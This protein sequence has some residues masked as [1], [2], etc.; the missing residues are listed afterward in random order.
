M[1]TQENELSLSQLFDVFKKSLIR[2]LIY[3]LVTIITATAVL[4]LVKTFSSTNVY[5]ANISFSKTDETTLSTL[6]SYKANAVNKAIAADG[7]SLDISDEII[8]NLAVSAI[9]PEDKEKDSSFTPTSF[10][11]SLKTDSDLKL[12][13][14]EYKSL[15]DNI[16]KE[17]VNQFAASS[18]P[19]LSE[20]VI[21]VGAQ[22]ENNVE[23]LQIAYYLSDIIDDYLINLESFAASNSAAAVFA[24]SNGKTL[25]GVISDLKF[26]KSYIDSLKSTIVI[27]K[28]GLGNLN[29]Y[30][31]VAKIAADAKFSECESVY[32]AAKASLEAY[33]STVEEMT[34]DNNGNNVYMFD[35]SFTTLAETANLAAKQ[36]GAAK[37]KQAEIDGFVE[38]I[39]D[40]A[41]TSDENVA[42][43]LTAS[44]TTLSTAFATY[45]SLASEFND[46]KTVIS[47]AT[48][49]KPAYSVAESFINIKIILIADVAFALIAYLFAFSQTF[50]IMKK[51]GQLN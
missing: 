22:L 7:K 3:V 48:V 44:A 45:K 27:G 31:A 29:A 23:Y 30:I 10:T 24:A 20:N 2:G 50:T 35:D 1:D 26:L 41:G 5:S 46:N 11:V 25:N 34:K 9:I 47:S 38:K 13:S 16:A 42:A 33:K 19:E 21:N 18:M 40:A 49:S 17:F 12:S 14:G 51:K 39:G 15:V 28:K 36:L 6:T 43:Q 32:N 8:A 4:V 37:Y